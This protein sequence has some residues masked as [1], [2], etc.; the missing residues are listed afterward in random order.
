MLTLRYI[1]FPY[2][3]Y[4][5]STY[6]GRDETGSVYL[7]AHSAGA[8]TATLLVMVIVV[9]GGGRGRAPTTLTSQ[10]NFNDGMDARKRPLLLCVLCVPTSRYGSKVY[11]MYGCLW[12]TPLRDGKRKTLLNANVIKSLIHLH[13]CVGCFMVILP[14][15]RY[16]FCF[17]P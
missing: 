6:I 11:N 10:A 15:I 8:Y 13:I 1:G 4:P 14:I 12:F 16:K 5:Q 3:T 9:K 17:A 2:G 7:H